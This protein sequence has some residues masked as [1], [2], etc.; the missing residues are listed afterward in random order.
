MLSVDHRDQTTSND[1]TTMMLDDPFLLTG[2][3][4]EQKKLVRFVSTL[5]D[6][7]FDG[8]GDFFVVLLEISTVMSVL[9]LFW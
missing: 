5:F 6:D 1:T 4:T 7:M 8:Q 9:I 3:M 2:G